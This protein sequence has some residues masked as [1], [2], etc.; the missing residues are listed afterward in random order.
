MVGQMGGLDDTPAAAAAPIQTYTVQQASTLRKR[1]A[2]GGGVGR[3]V[4]PAVERGGVVVG[5]LLPGYS[6]SV[7]PG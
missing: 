6:L 1:P 7:C 3:V 2:T 5:L 4:V